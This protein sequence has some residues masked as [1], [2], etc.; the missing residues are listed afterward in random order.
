[1]ETKITACSQCGDR[2]WTMEDEEMTPHIATVM[3]RCQSCNHEWKAQILL[4]SGS[5]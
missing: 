3:Y 2:N 1:M 5:A 4:R